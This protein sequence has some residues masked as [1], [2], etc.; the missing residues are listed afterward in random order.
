MVRVVGDKSAVFGIT[1]TR[2]IFAG[3]VI[4]VTDRLETAENCCLA[5]SHIPNCHLSALVTFSLSD[6]QFSILCMWRIRRP[7][8]SPVLYVVQPS[9][10]DLAHIVCGAALTTRPHPW[11]ISGTVVTPVPGPC[12][13]AL[14]NWDPADGTVLADEQV[15]AQGR[16]WRSGALVE[17]RLLRQWFVRTTRFSE[18]LLRSLDSAQLRDWR[19]VIQVQRH[20]IGPCDG[21]KFELQV[22]AAR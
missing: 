14:V 7:S 11:C 18:R 17:R 21:W 15:D 8:F 6:L 2:E 9:P 1:V 4:G 5:S 22:G 12:R 3:V 13:Q 19:D 16:S 20:W 10:L